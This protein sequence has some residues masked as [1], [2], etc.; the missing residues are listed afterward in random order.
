[1]SKLYHSVV[2]QYSIKLVAGENGL[3]NAVKWVHMVENKEISSFLDGQEIVFTTGIGIQTPEDLLALIK[4][5]VRNRASGMVVN[6]GPYI[7]EVTPEMLDYCN[8]VH[9]PLF[10][11]PWQVKMARIIKVFCSYILESEKHEVEL[12]SAVQNAIYSPD[13]TRLYVPVFEEH[14]FREPG[15]FH[16]AIVD[17]GDRKVSEEIRVD[18]KRKIEYRLESFQAKVIVADVDTSFVLFFMDVPMERINDF[19]EKLLAFMNAKYENDMFRIAIGNQVSRLS[20]L[21][22]SYT[23]ACRILQISGDTAEGR[24]ITNYSEIGAYKVLL[25]LDRK[26]ISEA[27][28][29]ETIG[30]LIEYDK[31]NNSDFVQVLDL[32]LR[33]S[34]RVHPVAGTLFV[35]RNTINYKLKR[36]E[37]LLDCDLSDFYVRLNLA[38]ALM[39][40]KIT[41]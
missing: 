4:E 26:E 41:R 33:H 28:I 35:H 24:F 40:R 39:L 37:K 18:R 23:Q 10:V 29:Q 17:A 20:E 9:F 22:K 25:E 8:E 14:G 5:N 1:M 13:Q 16:V 31:L 2:G 3:S 19:S 30:P 38:V 27:Y 11:V 15:K 21:V 32:Y 34:G 12:A 36:I 7:K 6:I